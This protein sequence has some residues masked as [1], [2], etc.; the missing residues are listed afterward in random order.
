MT[1]IQAK[2]RSTLWI[3]EKSQ[4]PF[5]MNREELKDKKICSMFIN[6]AIELVLQI[7]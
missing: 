3:S 6:D 7:S 5:K 4:N 1:V 2:V